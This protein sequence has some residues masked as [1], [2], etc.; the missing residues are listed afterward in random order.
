MYIV[1]QLMRILIICRIEKFQFDICNFDR[2]IDIF[3]FDRIYYDIFMMLCVYDTE[4]NMYE[5][6]IMT[7]IYDAF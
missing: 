7:I 4:I 5:T 1:C 6:I 2:V 3:G